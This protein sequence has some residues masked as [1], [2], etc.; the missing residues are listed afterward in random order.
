MSKD[1]QI[2]FEYV[3]SKEYNPIYCNGAYGGISSHGE[4]IANFF[5]ERMPIAKSTTNIVNPD[6]SL[7]GEVKSE[8]EE[9]NDT[10]IRYITNG[11]IL[12]KN[13]AKSIYDW[14]GAQIEEL[15]N[16]GNTQAESN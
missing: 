10:I 14:L 9:L 7:G 1:R 16:R 3:Y 2:T 13:D 12:N 6:G 5:L 11:I 8:P 15:E 4:I